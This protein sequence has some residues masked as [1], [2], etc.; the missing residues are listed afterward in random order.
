MGAW[1]VEPWAND[2]AA[3][4]FGDTFDE[5]GLA[6]KIEQTLNLD[7]DEYHEEIRAAAFLVR[8]LARTYIWPVDDIDRHRTLAADRLQAIFDSGVFEGE[9]EFAVGGFLDLAK[10]SGVSL[11]CGNGDY[12][13]GHGGKLGWF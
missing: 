2:G 1:G 9:D 4:W 3:D 8:L 10:Q 7:I 12:E 13:G 6:K 11:K 5:T